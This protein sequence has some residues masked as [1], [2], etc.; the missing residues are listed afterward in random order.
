MNF[1]EAYA[2]DAI[3]APVKRKMEAADKRALSKEA[4]DKEKDD[5]FQ[6]WQLKQWRAWR[7]A[8]REALLAG[9]HGKDIRGLVAFMKTMTLSSAPALIRLVEEAAW[10]RSLS[11]DERADLLSLMSGGITRLRERNGLTPFDD[12]LPGQPESAFH[13]IQKVLA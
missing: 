1:F 13:Q 11:K 7:K 9:P 2:D 6:T 4:I 3:A 12:A 8:K 5:A 10:A